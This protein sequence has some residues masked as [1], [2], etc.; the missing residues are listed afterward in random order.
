MRYFLT[1]G[2]RTESELKEMKREAEQD[3]TPVSGL[4]FVTTYL[5][6]GTDVDIGCVF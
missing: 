4:S 1:S 3:K 5:C 2:K 6:A